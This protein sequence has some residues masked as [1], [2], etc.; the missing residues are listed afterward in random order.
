MATR[1]NSIDAFNTRSGLLGFAGEGSSY[2]QSFADFPKGKVALAVRAA[3]F[4][5]PEL[6][7]RMRSIPGKNIV[8]LRGRTQWDEAYVQDALQFIYEYLEG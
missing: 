7:I 6:I 5:F 4:Q 3:R 1:Y 8:F 2:E